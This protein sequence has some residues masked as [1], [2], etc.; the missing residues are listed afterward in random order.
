MTTTPSSVGTERTTQESLAITST[1]ASA[2][3]FLEGIGQ[4]LDHAKD[5]SADYVNSSHVLTLSDHVRAKN[6]R[7]L[8]WSFGFDLKDLCVLA[9][10]LQAPLALRGATDRGK[11]HLAARVLTGLFGPQGKG[12]W[13]IEVNRGITI[14]DLIDVDVGR[15]STSKLS[16]AISS[17]AWVSLPATLLDEVNRAHAKLINL[18]LHVIDG[19]GLNVR[20]DLSIPIGLP[21]IAHG[22]PKRYS[23]SILTANELGADT[24]GTYEED[25]ALVRRVVLAFNIDL[26]PVTTRDVA[27]LTQGSGKR[28][29]AEPLACES[30][31]ESVIRVYES[32][33]A[34]VPMSALAR[35]FLHYLW[36]L[37]S[38]IRTRTGRLRKDLIPQ[39]CAAC[40]LSKA[41]PFCGRV[42]GLS[43]GLLIWCKEIAMGLAAIR[44]AKVLQAERADCLSG[45]AAAI[46]EFLGSRS[47][48]EDLYG[49]FAETYARELAVKGEDMVA[50]YSLLAPSH[51]WI[52][53]E[54]VSSQPAYEK[55]DAYA[56]ADIAT[57]SWRTLREIL[58]KH[59]PLF[60]ELAEN[61]EVSPT[62]QAEVEALITTE[63]AAMLSVIAAFRDADLGLR[64]SEGS[65]VDKAA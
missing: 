17:A 64:F 63:D 36:G 14:D 42:A 46:Q 32:L 50:A 7:S 45:R 28:A 59:E 27:A 12:W 5:A 65:R 8:T 13:R 58:R 53:R 56:F 55:S 34:M 40:H 31:V 26:V 35:L 25:A 38:C 20:G 52:S 41:H 2:Q 16:A 18:L 49:A 30:L 21:Y 6:G 51:L 48:G 39:I 19:S 24:P 43:E 62:H 9:A 33:P 1:W 57:R 23:L 3:A 10:I 61:G 44:A 37:G 54:F 60:S 22:Q 4:L 11:T 47:E 29:K 15:L